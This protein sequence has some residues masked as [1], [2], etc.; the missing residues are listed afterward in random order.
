MDELSRDFETTI[1]PSG[2]TLAQDGA[3]ASIEAAEEAITSTYFGVIDDPDST[4]DK[5][6]QAT[7]LTLLQAIAY[8]L[9]DVAAAIREVGGRG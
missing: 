3:Q 4:D 1:T 7:Q 2:W 5:I 9:L 8:G 6:F